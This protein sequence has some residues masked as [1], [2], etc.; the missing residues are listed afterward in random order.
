VSIG[1][2]LTQYRNISRQFMLIFAAV[3]PVALILGLL[4]GWFMPRRA[5]Y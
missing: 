1:I 3:I 2:P 4:L 5:S